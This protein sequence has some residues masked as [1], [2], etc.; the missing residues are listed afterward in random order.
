MI[1]LLLEA[2][3]IRC[4]TQNVNAL[5]NQNPVTSQVQL[6]IIKVDIF[7]FRSELC[8]LLFLCV[9]WNNLLI[10]GFTIA[11]N[12]F[13]GSVHLFTSRS[14]RVVV[15]NQPAAITANPP[16]STYLR[17][18]SNSFLHIQPSTAPYHS[19]KIL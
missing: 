15:I 4:R 18:P 19:P 7:L 1:G 6:D 17:L 5:N 2:F 16:S 11:R 8:Q 9:I 14:V 3:Q 13:P 10:L 12:L